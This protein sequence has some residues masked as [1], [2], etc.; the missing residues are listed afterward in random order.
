MELLRNFPGVTG[1]NPEESLEELQ[2]NFWQ[3]SGRISGENPEKVPRNCCI[4]SSG[5]AGGNSEEFLDG[6]EKKSWRYLR[7]IMRGTLKEFPEEFLWETNLR[8]KFWSKSLEE[9]LGEIPGRVLG[10]NL[11][12]S[13]L[14]KFAE[15]FLDETQSNCYWKSHEKV[16]KQISGGVLGEYFWRKYF[17]NPFF[18]HN[19]YTFTCFREKNS[20]W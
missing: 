13:F 6:L 7:G 10:G 8:R 15:V 11:R 18:R 20:N 12:R 4:K 17:R 5:I 1:W 16:L 2:R 3:N 9:F 14:R 19:F